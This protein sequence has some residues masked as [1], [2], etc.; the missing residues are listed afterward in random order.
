M[1][2]YVIDTDVL[3]LYYHRN[4][5]VIRQVIAHAADELAVAVISV[6]EVM[7]GRLGFIKRQTRPDQTAYGYDELAG[8]VPFLACFTILPY[9]ES[10]MT[11]FAQLRGRCRNVGPNDLRIAAV[12]LEHGATVVTR[13]LR[14]FGR[15][16][17]VTAEDWAA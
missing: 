12:A 7:E 11:L 3:G 4:V 9:R 16:P 14:D 2:L 1:S 10:T 13:N 17:G 6:Q 5:N 8:T 15:I